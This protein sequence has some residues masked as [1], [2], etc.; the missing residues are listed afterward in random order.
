MAFGDLLGTFTV[1]LLTIVN[2]TD[3]AGSAVVAVNDLVVCVF[4]QQSNITVTAVT[5]NLGNTYTALGTQTDVGNTTEKA[6]YSLVTVAGTITVLHGACT[7]STNNV[8]FIGAAF[9]GPFTA[10]PLDAVPATGTTDI[11]SPFTCPLSGTLAQADE[12]VVAIGCNNGTTAYVATSP[13]LLALSTSDGALITAAIGR[14]VVAATTS[15]A[16]EFTSSAN[17]AQQVLR[18]ASFKKAAGGGAFNRNPTMFLVF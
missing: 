7:G 17:P 14:Q 4:S 15:I 18:T 3:A 2:P 16:P 13:N 10:S 12:L 5:D 9:A 11:T 1:N 6:F 8:V